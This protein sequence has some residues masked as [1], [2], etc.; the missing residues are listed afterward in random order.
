MNE[1]KLCLS[2]KAPLIVLPFKSSQGD[3]SYTH[4]DIPCNGLKDSI[5]I[6]A[7]IDNEDIQAKWEEIYGKPDMDDYARV[8]V[9]EEENKSLK[10]TLNHPFKIILKKWFP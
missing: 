9:L 7:T 5:S 8:G 4:P 10:E 6:E 3:L 2:C 1:R